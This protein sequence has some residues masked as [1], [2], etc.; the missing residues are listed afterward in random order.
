MS[1]LKPDNLQKHI[2]FTNPTRGLRQ[3]PKG[4]SIFLNYMSMMLGFIQPLD[5]LEASM[6]EPR[7]V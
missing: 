4:N 6:T 7:I 1:T 2:N 5:D 3:G